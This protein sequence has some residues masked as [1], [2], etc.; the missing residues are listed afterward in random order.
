MNLTPKFLDP[1]TCWCCA[2]ARAVLRVSD[3]LQRC[4]LGEHLR[5]AAEGDS[6]NWGRPAAVSDD[7][8][9]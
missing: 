4:V 1:S 6:G 9:G 7:G 8:F 2:M 5:S 3:Q